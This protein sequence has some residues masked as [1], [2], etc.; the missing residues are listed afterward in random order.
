MLNIAQTI[1]RRKIFSTIGL[2]IILLLSL[3]G[4]SIWQITRL[5]SVMNWV[6]HTDQVIA[7]AYLTQKL[8]VDLETGVRGYQLTGNREFLQHYQQSNSQINAAFDRLANLVS[9]NPTQTQRL[10]LLRVQ[11]INWNRQI[12]QVIA[13]KE[14]GETEPLAGFQLRKGI[15]DRI[16]NEIANFIT[17]EE[18]LRTERTQAVQITTIQI[19]FTSVA[20]AI[21]IGIFLG[22]FIWRQVLQVSQNYQ[23]ALTI[24]Q[25]QAQQAQRAAQRLAAL[26]N[27]DKAILRAES[28]ESLINNALVKMRE[29]LPYQQA[30]VAVFDFEK[31]TSKIIAGSITDKELKPLIGTQLP[32]TDFAAKARELQNIRYIPDLATAESCPPILVK[33]RSQGICC[34]LCIPMFVEERLFGEMN[35]STTVVDAFDE[36]AHSIASEVTAQLAIAIQ[37]SLLREQIQSYANELEERVA[38]RTAQLQETN[39]ELEAF[40]YTISHD[41]RAPLRTMQGFAQA[42]QEDYT[43][44]LDSVGQE[45]IQY[46]TEGAL[47]MDTLIADLLAYSR[48]SRAQIEMQKVDLTGVVEEALKQ[49]STELQQQQAQVTVAKPL[50]LVIAHRSTLV[51]VVVNLLSNAMKFVQPGIQ[52]TIQ[53]YAEEQQNWIQLSVLDNGIGIA[54][55]HQERIFRVFERLH[56]VETYP[57]TGI[58]LAIVRKGVERMNGRAG[59]E[60]QLGAGSRFWIALPKAVPH[61][62]DS[63][64]ASTPHS[65][66]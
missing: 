64:D 6:E 36:E 55:E 38:E 26:H 59:V 56:G 60:S 7:Q 15:M 20:L 12:S 29:I 4:I 22:Y 40:T 50:P 17:T 42:L 2:P 3:S 24:A 51:Q 16:R 57:G 1:F 47:Q 13:R 62:N 8:L 45:Y 65:D 19:I 54:P 41:L 61:S 49:I 10:R 48:L 9:D 11:Q 32:L 39:Q 33:L 30:F 18:Q 58:G 43:D 27:I 5:L 31:S 35:L 14:R 21:V 25:Q 37:Q 34:S 46:I 66:N 23:T 28:I 63:D 53:I 52:P 44:K